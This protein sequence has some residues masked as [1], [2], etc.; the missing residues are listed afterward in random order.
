MNLPGD[1]YLVSSSK[2]ATKK[3]SFL[4]GKYQTVDQK[5]Y[6]VFLYVYILIGV[7]V[8]ILLL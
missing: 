8:H 5:L 1:R 3:F 7:Y 4:F 2:L 6:V